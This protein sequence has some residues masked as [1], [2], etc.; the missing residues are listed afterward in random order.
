MSLLQVLCLKFKIHVSLLYLKIFAELIFTQLY[1]NNLSTSE[2]L[3]HCLILL[4]LLTYI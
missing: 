3:F 1:L 4:H 2:H